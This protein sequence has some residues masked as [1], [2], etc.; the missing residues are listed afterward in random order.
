MTNTS[1]FDASAQAIGYLHQVRSAL[2]AAVLH[3][4]SSDMLSLEVVDDVSFSAN[5]GES[6]EPKEVLQYKHSISKLASLTD[7]SVDLWKTIRVWAE[8]IKSKSLDPE[9]TVFAL[10]T[11]ATASPKSAVASLRKKGRNS[12][13]A[14]SKIEAAGS[15]S[16]GKTVSNCFDALK[17]LKISERKCLFANMF[18]IDRSPDILEARKLIEH[19]L[20]YSVDEPETQLRGFADRLEGWWFR[21]AVAHLADKSNLGIPVSQVQ[22]KIRD[23]LDQFKR[24]NLPNDLLDAIVPIER[25][26]PDDDRTFV[27]ELRRII[28][29]RNVIRI[30]QDN[31]YRAFEQRSKWVRETLLGIDEEEDYESRLLLEWANKVSIALD[32]FEEL[33]DSEKLE[34]GK[35]IYT[36][37]QDSAGTSP[38]FFIRREFVSAYMARGSFHMLVDKRRMVWHPDDIGNLLGRLLEAAEHA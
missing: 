17:K 14:R 22:R 18:L 3:D 9:H 37:L 34:L 12:E 25:L 4:E 2:L 27:V 33:T 10:V 5:N 13:E 32:G 16:N 7:K 28:D 31:H 38:S 21:T 29:N 1:K 11:T 24:D 20:R 35:N 36:W 6:L 8:R 19:E 23:L 26:K 15:E 30:A